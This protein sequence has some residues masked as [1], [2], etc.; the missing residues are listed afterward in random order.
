MTTDYFN[1][2][3]L[4]VLAQSLIIDVALIKSLQSLNFSF[5]CKIKRICSMSLES[6]EILS[7]ILRLK[8][9]RKKC[10][11][12][13]CPVCISIAALTA[14]YSNQFL[15]SSFLPLK[16]APWEQEWVP[17]PLVP[18]VERRALSTHGPKVPYRVDEHAG[19][20]PALVPLDPV[21]CLH[22]TSP[23]AWWTQEKRNSLKGPW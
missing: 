2:I 21:A 7:L 5:N 1:N 8:H 17:L 9:Y 20:T 4:Y 3:G 13:W 16:R 18:Q 15:N 14:I 12:F 10:S 23:P 22:P 11:V 6:L 19:S